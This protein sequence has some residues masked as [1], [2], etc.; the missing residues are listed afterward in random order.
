MEGETC[1]RAATSDAQGPEARQ[2]QFG[3]SGGGNESGVAVGKSDEAKSCA[4]K[5]GTS[6]EGI[7]GAL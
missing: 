7:N 2:Q 6:R 1:V 3:C 5:K 4:I